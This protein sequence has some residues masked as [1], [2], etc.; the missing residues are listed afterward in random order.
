MK[1]CLNK[2]RNAAYPS[3]AHINKT[4]QT[5]KILNLHIYYYYHILLFISASKIEALMEENISK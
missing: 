2:V 3:Y 5:Y 4:R 1:I